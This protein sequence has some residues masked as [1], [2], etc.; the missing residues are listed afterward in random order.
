MRG[1]TDSAE[2]YVAALD[3][4]LD[5]IPAEVFPPGFDPRAGDRAGA[6]ARLRDPVARSRSRR[7]A[8]SRRADAQVELGEHLTDDLRRLVRGE[9]V[10]ALGLGNFVGEG[11]H[12]V[13]AAHEHVTQRLT[14]RLRIVEPLD[15]C[16]T[17]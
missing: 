15:R 5:V 6:R 11:L 7:R 2:W 8:A 9:R 1:G 14:A 17:A 12:R 4:A 10:A 16:A 13:H 3:R